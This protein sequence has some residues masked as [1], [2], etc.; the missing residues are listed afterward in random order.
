LVG[1]LRCAGAREVASPRLGPARKPS[2]L[3]RPH[4]IDQRQSVNLLSVELAVL[5]QPRDQLA[6][7]HA[8]STGDQNMHYA[9]FCSESAGSK[10]SIRRRSGNST[11]H[12]P[13]TSSDPN[14][15]ITTDGTAPSHAAIR[16]DS[17]SPN[18]FDEPTNR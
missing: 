4:D 8:C 12:T 15:P 16:P 10:R 13:A 14:P 17:N 1:C 3:F 11:I 18:V 7:N 5:D 6:A 9:L 2:R